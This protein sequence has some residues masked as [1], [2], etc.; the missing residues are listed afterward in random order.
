[1]PGDTK[2]KLDEETVLEVRSPTAVKAESSV[3]VKA[4]PLIEVEVGFAF[5]M[6]TYFSAEMLASAYARYGFFRIALPT[7]EVIR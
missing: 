4:T 7:L 1:V 3:G 5:I 2:Y 6:K